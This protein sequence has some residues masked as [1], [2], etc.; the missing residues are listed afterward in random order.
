MARDACVPRRER[1]HGEPD[2]VVERDE[3][4]WPRCA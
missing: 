2:R 3:R 1:L 4:Q